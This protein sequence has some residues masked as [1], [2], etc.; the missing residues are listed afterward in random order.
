[1]VRQHFQSTSN[2]S[3]RVTRFSDIFVRPINTAQVYYIFIPSKSPL[4][5]YQKY[6]AHDG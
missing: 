6:Y 3:L 4:S 5:L 1:M 2:I